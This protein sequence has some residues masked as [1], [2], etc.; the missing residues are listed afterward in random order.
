MDTEE[1][2]Q[3]RSRLLTVS[4]L[5]MRTSP[6]VPLVHEFVSIRVNSWFPSVIFAQSRALQFFFFSTKV[7]VDSLR[8]VF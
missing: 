2:L 1:S 6:D 3:W 4:P 5:Q 8:E 7:L